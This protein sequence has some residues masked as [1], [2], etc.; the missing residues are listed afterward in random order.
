MDYVPLVGAGGFGAVVGWYLYFIN[1]YRKADVQISD[2][3]TVIGA[4]GGG[5][6][7]KLFGGSG[8]NADTYLFGAY[9]I[10]IAI[11]FFGYFILL[12]VLVEQSSVFT[13]DWFLDGRRPNP[14]ADWGYGADAQQ[15]VRPMAVPTVAG[16]GGT[17][18]FY[19]NPQAAHAPP[20]GAAGD[21]KVECPITGS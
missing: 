20:T 17:Q 10:G 8:G 4:I 6:V 5:A 9:G 13:A 19:I 14:P 12:I 2:L 7:L 11:G 16:A 15:P 1:R 3:T 18:N 21:A